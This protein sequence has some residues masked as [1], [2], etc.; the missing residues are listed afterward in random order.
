MVIHPIRTEADNHAVVAT[1]STTPSWISSRP[2]PK[3]VT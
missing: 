2:T 1:R 3:P